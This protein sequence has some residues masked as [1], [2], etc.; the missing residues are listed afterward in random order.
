MKMITIRSVIHKLV[1][2]YTKCVYTSLEN[3]LIANLVC[4]NIILR[5][6]HKHTII[7]VVLFS[8]ISEKVF[9]VVYYNCIVTL[10]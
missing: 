5:K 9:F 7:L 2:S 6:I 1:F 10:T 4:V 3:V 8:F